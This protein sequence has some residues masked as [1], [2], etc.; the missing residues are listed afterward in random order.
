MS[1]SISETTQSSI[2][3]ILPMTKPKSLL[4]HW[5]ALGSLIVLLCTSTLNCSALQPALQRSPI[6]TTA[7][8]D[9]ATVLTTT[10]ASHA[11]A[12]PPNNTQKSNVILAQDRMLDWMNLALVILFLGVLLLFVVLKRA[13]RNR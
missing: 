3:N 7:S 6:T 9:F 2:V 10:P 1:C 4:R 13:V 5:Y 11:P 8:A 12:S